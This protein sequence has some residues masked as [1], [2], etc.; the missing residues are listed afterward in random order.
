MLTVVQFAATLA[1]LGSIQAQEP[2]RITGTLAE[3]PVPE[4]GMAGFELKPADGRGLPEVGEGDQVFRATPPAFRAVG[5][6]G[7]E[8]AFVKGASQSYL[9]VDSDFDGRFT[10][11]ERHPY[12]GDREPALSLELKV[13]GGLPLPFRC[14]V[15]SVPS[16]DSQPR[17]MLMFTAGYRIEGHAEIG[18]RK[19]LVSLPF[20]VARN[21]IDL[22]QGKL[23]VDVNGDGQIDLRGLNGPEVKF[24]RGDRIM[25]RVGQT[26]VSFESADLGSRR[27]VLRE[28]AADEYTVIDIQVGSPLPDF[29]FT[30]FDGKPRKL[31]DF[32][33]KHLLIDVWGSWCKPCVEDLPKLK[34]AHDRFKDKG[35]EILGIDYENSATVEQVRALLK[36]K[37]VSWPN[38][39]PD[40]VKELVRERWR[41]MAFP[42]LILLDP[43]G[44]VIE[45]SASLRGPRLTATLERLL[46]KR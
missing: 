4:P 17:R 5:A 6:R 46:E 16:G 1:L 38:A 23:G 43:N 31:S 8:V 15:A 33:G 42:T 36:E 30:D 13:P 27:F 34:E 24:A 32:R 22:T 28:H 11:A 18:G 45:T 3:R 25:F 39:L 35:F 40:T 2:Q 10:K 7:L 9:F 20:H 44:V 26:Y 41:I 12:G 29:S 19:T 37:N 21:I 14:S